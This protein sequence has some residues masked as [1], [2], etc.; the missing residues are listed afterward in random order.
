VVRFGVIVYALGQLIL[1]SS[2]SLEYSVLLRESDRAATKRLASGR[3]E[4]ERR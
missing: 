4:K 2:P 3:T 1:W